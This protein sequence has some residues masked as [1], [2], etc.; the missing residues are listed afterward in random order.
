MGWGEL[1][2]EEPHNL[3]SSIN[4]RIMERLRLVACTGEMKNKTQ[5]LK[6]RDFLVACV[7]VPG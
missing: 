1:R 7:S 2:T 4:M 5:S 3:G 6:K